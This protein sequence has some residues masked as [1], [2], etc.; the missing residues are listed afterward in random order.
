MELTELERNYIANTTPVDCKCAF[1]KYGVTEEEKKHAQIEE[2][3]R[4]AKYKAERKY[5]AITNKS[6]LLTAW[7]RLDKGHT[8]LVDPVPRFGIHSKGVTRYGAVSELEK[9]VRDGVTETE[10]YKKEEQKYER[11]FQSCVDA[12]AKKETARQLKDKLTDSQFAKILEAVKT[13]KA[14]E[15]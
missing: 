1:H 4:V 2:A 15:L 10:A 7:E 3:K 14:E 5:E 6:E 12:Q 9:E 8:V 13:I 11:I